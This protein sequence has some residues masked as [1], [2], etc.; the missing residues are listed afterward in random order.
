[1]SHELTPMDNEKQIH[2]RIQQIY[3]KKKVTT[4][5]GIE[6]EMITDILKELR[7]KLSCG[8]NLSKDKKVVQLQGDYSF[9]IGDVLG[10]ML[11]DVKIV[12]HGKK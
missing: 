6:D 2:V 5:T 7:R 11:G 8:G 4:I 12:V 9:S 1:M 10:R 3:G